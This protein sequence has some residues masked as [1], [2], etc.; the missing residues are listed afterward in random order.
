M[1]H[2]KD[3]VDQIVQH[4]DGR[5]PE[6]LVLKYRAIA[7]NP[8]SFLRGTCHLFYH[9]LPEHK[10]LSE[11][12]PAWL[13]GDLHIENLGTYRGDNGLIYFDMND[14]DEA[15]LAP[16]TWETIR[17]LA[18]ILVAAKTLKI[19]EADAYTMAQRTLDAYAHTLSVGKAKWIDRDGA[20]GLI[21]D[22]FEHIKKRTRKEFI[23]S[24]TQ[25]RG[26]HLVIRTDTGKALPV[27]DADRAR[28]THWLGEYAA[29]QAN[30]DFFRPLDIARRIA[31]TGSLGIERFA[32]L[33]DGKGGTDGHYLLDLKACIPS[34]LQ[35][36]TPN[37]QPHWANEADRVATVGARVQAVAPSFLQAVMLDDKPFV[38]KGL[39]PTSDSVDLE[40]AA[41]HLKHLDHLLCQFGAIAA[42]G[43]LRASGRQGS[44]NADALIEFANDSKQL[45]KL[46]DLA[47]QM[48]DGVE[49]DWKTFAEKSKGLISDTV[50]SLA[51]S[52]KT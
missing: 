9:Q 25:M 30:P 35:K 5:D 21:G 51:K 50:K 20:D 31:G 8:F 17:L 1:A 29:K 10:V 52:L 13:C 4:N 23:E 6:R 28:V 22:L 44:A 2:S 7:D 34:C 40:H 19:A 11:A 43:Q 36:I 45:S 15:I 33:I 12:P 24:R 3:I 32:I 39:Q 48:A 26:Q 27:S 46:L 16:C 38:L 37:K 42:W 41:T 47:K 14:F 49:Q 18:S